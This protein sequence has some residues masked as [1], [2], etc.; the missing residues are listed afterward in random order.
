MASCAGTVLTITCM[1]TFVNRR[2]NGL[3]QQRPGW[4]TLSSILPQW[5]TMPCSYWR[6]TWNPN[7]VGSDLRHLSA[8]AVEGGRRDLDRKPGPMQAPGSARLVCPHTTPGQPDPEVTRQAEAQSHTLDYLHPTSQRPVR[9]VLANFPRRVVL[10]H[11]SA[12]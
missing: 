5:N 6:M 2:L 7:M 12:Q 10:D 4:R 1:L 9:T 3:T 8:T 11:M